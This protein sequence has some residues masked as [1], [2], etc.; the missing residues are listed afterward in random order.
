MKS[1]KKNNNNNKNGNKS[2]AEQKK[3]LENYNKVK[4]EEKAKE[5]ALKFAPA[6]AAA[7]ICAYCNNKGH[8]LRDKKTRRVTCPKLMKKEEYALRKN[9]A[10]RA[11]AESWQAQTSVK[12]IEGGGG[13]GWKTTGSSDKTGEGHS[14]YRKPVV[15]VSNSYDFGADEWN[16][17]GAAEERADEVAEAA[18]EA[19]RDEREAVE[20]DAKKIA[21][22]AA[23]VMGRWNKPLS[24]RGDAKGEAVKEDAIKCPGCED[25][26]CPDCN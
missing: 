23:A 14:N 2:F 20:R 7:P 9:A 4:G 25:W 6:A 15:Q 18:S 10:K 24:Y 26:S 16:E 5:K 12:A 21:E 17:I 19:E 3:M 1:F 13:G 8:W 22:A 11:A